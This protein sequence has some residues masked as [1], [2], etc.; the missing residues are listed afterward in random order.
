MRNSNSNNNKEDEEGA[1]YW[2]PGVLR[3]LIVAAAVRE[4]HDQEMSNNNKDEEEGAGG[5]LGAGSGS[6]AMI[7]NSNSSSREE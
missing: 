1:G 7:D 5:V 2:V 4:S 3:V 6:V